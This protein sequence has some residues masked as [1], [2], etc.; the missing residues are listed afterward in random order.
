MFLLGIFS[1]QIFDLQFMFGQDILVVPCL[2][3]G[4][5]VEYMLPEGDWLTFPGGEPVQGGQVHQQQLA[6]DEMA[7][8]VRQGAPIPI[9]PAVEHTESLAGEV[10]VIGH[11]PQQ[12]LGNH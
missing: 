6:L 4:G 10:E 2:E 7:V 3:P 5:K 9:G 12:S 8:F 1:H 11:W